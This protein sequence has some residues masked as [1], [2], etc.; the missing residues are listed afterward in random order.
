M[1]DLFAITPLVPPAPPVLAPPAPLKVGK[2]AAVPPL[3]LAPLSQGLPRP[4]LRNRVQNWAQNEF[5]QALQKLEQARNKHAQLAV[6][7]QH[8]A[9][10]DNT[11]DGQHGT[12]RLLDYTQSYTKGLIRIAKSF[13]DRYNE[14]LRIPPLH[15]SVM[16]PAYGL[17]GQ[18]GDEVLAAL[19]SVF[20]QFFD[21]PTRFQWAMFRATCCAAKALIYGDEYFA[22][23]NWV[24]ERN[25]WDDDCD[26]VGILTG[27]KTGKS[28]GLAMIA[29]TFMFV[30]AGVRIV[31]GSRTLAQS[32]IV[33][34][35][36]K[37]G[38]ILL[39]HCLR[40]RQNA[41]SAP[42]DGHRRTGQAKHHARAVF[43]R[44][45]D[46]RREL[47]GGQKW[48]RNGAY[49]FPFLREWCEERGR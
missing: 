49:S 1:E 8:Q 18:G 3:L 4:T 32:C 30:I 33:P 48:K 15:E 36:R 42:S 22:D 43:Q 20:S 11:R 23:P 40:S 9:E 41:H 14:M 17:R 28:T 29:L 13:S 25:G 37:N 47:T 31:V 26:L 46:G 21:K 6:E 34:G 10:Q 12:D 7:E 27:R 2:A 44:Q 5:Q 24:L 19:E 16:D 39:I 45:S 35:M 38:T